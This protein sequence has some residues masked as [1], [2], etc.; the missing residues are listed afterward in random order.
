LAEWAYVSTDGS[1]PDLGSLFKA[2]TLAFDA[3]SNGKDLGSS[4]PLGFSLACSPDNGYYA[5]T[6]ERYFKSLLAMNKLFIA[7]NAPFDR[8]MAKKSGVV[9]DNIAD[10]MVAAH[11]LE[12]PS[13]ALKN[14]SPITVKSFTELEHGFA[15]MSIR[16]IGQYSCPHAMATYGLWTEYEHRMKELSLSHVFWDIEMPL[17]PVLSDMELN[18]VM[19]DK[20]AL[21]E[22]GDVIEGMLGTLREAL[23]YWSNTSGVNYN[24]PDQ[25]ANIL[26]KKLGLPEHPWIKK[27]KSKRSTT[28]AKY[29]ET[30]KRYHSFVPV[31]LQYKQLMTLRNSYVRSLSKIIHDDGRVYC[32]FNQTGTRTGRLSSSE[33]NLQKVPVRTEL[34]RRIRTAFIAPEGHKLLVPDYDQLELRMLAICSKNPYLLDAFKNDRDIHVETATRAYRD[35]RRRSEAKTLNYQCLPLYYKA[36]TPVGWRGYGKLSIGDIVLAYDQ[37]SR[38]CKWTEVE[39]IVYYDKAPIVTFG[40]KLDEF[41]STPNHRWFGMQRWYRPNQRRLYESVL[42]SNEFFLH[43]SGAIYKRG[44]RE[45]NEFTRGPGTSEFEIVV[46]AISEGGMSFLNEDEASLLAWV[47]TDGGYKWSKLTGRTSQ[48]GGRKRNITAYISQKKPHFLSEIRQLVDKL[49]ARTG[50]EHVN[51]SGTTMIYLHPEYMRQLWAKA[52][53]HHMGLEQLVL[54]LKPRPRAKFLETMIKAEGETKGEVAQNV[55]DVLRAASLA[56]FLEGKYPRIADM[57][58]EGYPLGRRVIGSKPTITAQRFSVISS[59]EA[60]VWCIKTKYDSWVVQDSRREGDCIFIT[61]NTVY[62]GGTLKQSNTFFAAYPGVKEWITSVHE[63]AREAQYIRTLGGRIRTIE[64][65]TRENRIDTMG[66]PLEAHGDRE[67]ISTLIQGSSSEGVKT[68]MVRFWKPTRDTEVKMDIQVHDEVVTEVPEK[69]VMDVAKL[70][71]EKMTINDYEIP[72]TVSIKVGDNWGNMIK[73]EV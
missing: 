6:E 53:L 38:T 22:L 18:G 55:G 72:L 9:V 35:E 66:D 5:P 27:T 13:L 65:Y 51:N 58:R 15:N 68:G 37:F 34:G 70:M 12:K 24:S 43:T 49:G 14:L 73:L 57:S 17:V 25:L 1:E 28:D 54:T 26:Y 64:A 31:Y 69:L 16:D 52:G 36:L 63:E 29:L 67:T 60:P 46:S 39:D 30:I 4:I 3:E 71:K 8:S 10:T 7:H 47:H 33:P 62:G 40:N 56:F 42:S 59:T 50:K 32:K 2:P 23:D 21:S 45:T 48:A 19:V 11:L 44:V 20:Q 61:G 41:T